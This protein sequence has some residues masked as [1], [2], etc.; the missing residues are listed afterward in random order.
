MKLNDEIGCN[1]TQDKDG[2]L[3]DIEFEVYVNG[4]RCIT[5]FYLTRSE[6]ARLY[7]EYCKPVEEQ[8]K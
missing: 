1:A 3:N 5:Y 8:T 4:K 6:I 2:K 7:D